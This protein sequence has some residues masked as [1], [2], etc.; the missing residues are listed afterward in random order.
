MPDLA[1]GAVFAGHRIEGIAGKGGMGVVYRATHIALDHVV[2]LKVISPDLA[3]DER[4]RRRFGEESRIAVSIRHPNVVP[5]HHAGEQ[6]GL[7]FEAALVGGVEGERLHLPADRQQRCSPPA[8][9]KTRN[10]RPR[11]S[12]SIC[13]LSSPAERARGPTSCSSMV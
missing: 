2:A 13:S 4:F 7:L 8:S 5:I 11:R 3:Q 12:A 10:G 1:P 9:R 6:D